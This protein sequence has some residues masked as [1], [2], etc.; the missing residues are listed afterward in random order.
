MKPGMPGLRELDSPDLEVRERALEAAIALGDPAWFDA[1]LARVC[2]RDVGGEQ[3]ASHTFGRAYAQ[4]IVLRL[5]AS[6]PS[7]STVAA[8]LR[9]SIT[10]LR[11]RPL[12]C[13][14]WDFRCAD[15]TSLVNLRCLRIEGMAEARDLSALAALPRLEHL[16]VEFVRGP[17][18]VVGC[19]PVLRTL[20]V[21]GLELRTLETFDAPMLEALDLERVSLVPLAGLRAPRL[22]HLRLAKCDASGMT[23]PRDLVA[24]GAGPVT[25]ELVDH[26]GDDLTGFAGVES[27]IWR[28]RTARWAQFPPGLRRLELHMPGLPRGPLALPASLDQLAL[29]ICA[30]PREWGV[31]QGTTSLSG[32]LPHPALRTIRLL[33]DDVPFNLDVL[34]RCPALEELRIRACHRDELPDLPVRL[35]I[36]VGA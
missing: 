19:F 20:R 31:P 26:R 35:R 7:A 9:G 29:D 6:A 14:W 17:G 2:Y 12:N 3:W 22:S 15:L 24:R 32:L 16:A 5:V 33:G 25:V 34:A 18:T 36:R 1:A 28:S 30:P 23:F 13:T 10:S 11:L 21:N 4:W 27:L 8:R